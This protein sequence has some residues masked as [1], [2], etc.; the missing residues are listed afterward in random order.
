MRLSL[1]G[2]RAIPLALPDRF[3]LRDETHEKI[4]SE[5]PNSNPDV[6]LNCG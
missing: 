4:N 6:D 5:D 3:H 1:L 2:V